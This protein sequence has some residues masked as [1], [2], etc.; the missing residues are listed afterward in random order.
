MVGGVLNRTTGDR[1]RAGAGSFSLLRA[2]E[3]RL[4]V[5]EG[6]DERV[7]NGVSVGSR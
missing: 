1:I 6:D 7:L 4:N 5:D 2:G 3:G